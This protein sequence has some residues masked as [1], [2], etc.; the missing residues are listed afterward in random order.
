M[1]YTE[2]MGK[3]S[4]DLHD[5]YNDGESIEAEL[6]A[7]FA[8]AVDKKIELVEIIPGKGSGAL[9]ESVKRFLRRPEIKS[10]YHRYEVLE[11]NHGKMHVHFKF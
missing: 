6:N 1:V 11:K 10:M 3:I 8:K 9:M 5:I 7:A 2:S 4:L